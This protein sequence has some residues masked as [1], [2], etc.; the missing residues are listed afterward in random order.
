MFGGQSTK[1]R[2]LQMG[3][4]VRRATA[5]A[6]KSATA[7]RWRL[8]GLVLLGIIA[9]ADRGVYDLLFLHAEEAWPG[10]APGGMTGR[11]WQSRGTEHLEKFQIGFKSIHCVFRH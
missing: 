10:S 11:R 1:Y 6:S 2:L 8:Q 5:K 3:K 9:T 7:A 4:V